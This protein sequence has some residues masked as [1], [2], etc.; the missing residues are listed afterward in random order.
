[1]TKLTLFEKTVMCKLLHGEH[2]FLEN[3]RNQFL[4]CEVVSQNYTGMGFFI[5][6]KVDKKFA[7]GNVNSEIGDV[8]AKMDGIQHGIGFVLFI[9]QGLLSML[10][11]YTYDEPYPTEIVQYSLYYI[12][13]NERGDVRNLVGFP[14]KA[15]VQT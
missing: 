2:P 12:N 9:R 3:L 15:I 4:H 11:G 14:L 5:D 13:G 6:F 1:M 8:D 7:Y 10:E